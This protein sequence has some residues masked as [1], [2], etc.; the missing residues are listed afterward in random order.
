VTR[1]AFVPTV[2]IAQGG[3]QA[4]DMT[5]RQVTEALI[6]AHSDQPPDFSR[7]DLSFLDLSGL[8]F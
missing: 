1:I 4:A 7:K 2:L 6:S 5:V 3:A 8:D